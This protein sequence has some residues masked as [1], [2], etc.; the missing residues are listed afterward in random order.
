[1]STSYIIFVTQNL[2]VEVSV[3][4]KISK[5]I[6]VKITKLTVKGIIEQESSR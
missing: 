1:M 2:T 4:S 6:N 5:I 3:K